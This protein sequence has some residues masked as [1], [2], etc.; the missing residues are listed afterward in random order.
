M[1]FYY[2]VVETDIFVES[3]NP[4]F[5]TKLHF[6]GVL[7]FSRCQKEA[8]N[9]DS[10]CLFGWFVS[11]FVKEGV[12]L[13]CLCSTRNF[14]N[15]NNLSKLQLKNQLKNGIRQKMLN[16]L[17]AIMGNTITLKLRINLKCLKVY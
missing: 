8:F 1:L 14:P 9:S 13:A 15:A 6:R 5:V 7:F 3:I 10:F 17:M 16:A 2:S 4:F 11:L 12:C